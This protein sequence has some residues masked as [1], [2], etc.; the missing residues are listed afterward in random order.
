MF[1]L[2]DVN[3]RGVVI[4]NAKMQLMESGTDMTEF[5][6]QICVGMGMYTN[7]ENVSYSCA[8]PVSPDRYLP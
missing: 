4:M 8:V 2:Q 5:A 7:E 3:I 1:F 6:G